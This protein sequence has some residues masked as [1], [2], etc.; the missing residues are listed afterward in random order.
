MI[1]AEKSDLFDVLAYFSFSIKPITRT[2]RVE[3]AKSSIYEEL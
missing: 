1:D 2:E 3:E